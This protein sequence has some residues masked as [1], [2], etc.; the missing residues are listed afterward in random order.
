MTNERKGRGELFALLESS[1]A[2]DLL[3]DAYSDEEIEEILLQAG[4]DPEKVGEGGLNVVIQ[5][6]AKRAMS[7]AHVPTR[8]SQRRRSPR[9]AELIQTVYA[10][11]TSQRHGRSVADDLGGRQPEELREDELEELAERILSDED[12][13]KPS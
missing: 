8:S 6:L 3:T 10:A 13:D 7:Q 11:R 12:S 1:L 9:R 4:A 5:A 2:E